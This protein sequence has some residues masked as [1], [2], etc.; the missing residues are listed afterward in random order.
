MTGGGSPVAGPPPDAQYERMQRHLSRR[1]LGVSLVSVAV[2]V[3]A[4]LSAPGRSGGLHPRAL[5]PLPPGQPAERCTAADL[6]KPTVTVMP[7][8]RAVTSPVVIHPGPD[9][10]RLSPPDGN[11][12]VAPSE[13]WAVMRRKAPLAPTTAGSTSVLLGD[14]YAASPAVEH[15]LVW[16]IYDVHQP[17]SLPS[18]DPA[19]APPACYFESAVFYVDAM[20]G[21]PLVAEVFPPVTDPATAV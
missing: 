6:A 5:V 16:V 17:E 10:E 11:P 14:L 19:A 21:Q 2:G 15:R 8:P 9:L 12:A 4:V 7:T 18:S 20:T 13:A 1:A 3:T